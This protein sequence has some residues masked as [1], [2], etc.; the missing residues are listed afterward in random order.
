M[1]PLIT[2]GLAVLLLGETLTVPLLAAAG[3]ILGGV[4]IS[5]RT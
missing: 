3:F 5:Q 1:A 2:L 4:Y